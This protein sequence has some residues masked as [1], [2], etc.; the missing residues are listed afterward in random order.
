M[1]RLAV[2]NGELDDVEVTLTPNDADGVV[3]LQQLDAAD[4]RSG[5]CPSCTYSPLSRQDGILFCKS[6]GTS[7]K[8]I[9]DNVYEVI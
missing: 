3:Q 1:K 7:Y 6:C 4:V 5:R 8:V 9:D 2:T